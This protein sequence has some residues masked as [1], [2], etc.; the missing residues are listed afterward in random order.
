MKYDILTLVGENCI[1]REDGDKVY[2]LI[3]LELVAARPVEL[4]FAGVTI[5]ASPFFI[6]AVGRLL[7][8][9]TTEELNQL[10]KLYNLT[11]VGW[12]LLKLVVKHSAKYYGDPAFRKALDEVLSE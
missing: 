7:K 12:D 5:F 11:P 3:H 8:D 6:S 9:F 2:A 4:D 10:L 1:T